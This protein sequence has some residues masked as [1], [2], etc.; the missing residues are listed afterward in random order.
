M[1]KLL[2]IME[3][4]MG[5]NLWIVTTNYFIENGHVERRPKLL[6]PGHE[7]AEMKRNFLN[8]TGVTKHHK[9][10]LKSAAEA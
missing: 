1:E 2:T 3:F 4:V 6:K 5:N 9:F 10:W 8:G 7:H